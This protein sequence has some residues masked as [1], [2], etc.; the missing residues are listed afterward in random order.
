LFLLSF[1]RDNTELCIFSL[2]ALFFSS[3][4]LLIFPFCSLSCLSHTYYAIY[5]SINLLLYKKIW[6]FKFICHNFISKLIWN[7]HFLYLVTMIVCLNFMIK[8]SRE[9][10]FPFWYIKCDENGDQNTI[11][12]GTLHERCHANNLFETL[13]RYIGNKLHTVLR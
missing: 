11:C 3:H 7:F 10:S 12:A 8:I 5:C 9:N 6:R 1:N 2:F 13:F 4:S